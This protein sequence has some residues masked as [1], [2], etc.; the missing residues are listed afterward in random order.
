M[1]ASAGIKSP[2]RSRRNVE[3]LTIQS[4]D[5]GK[6]MDQNF[7]LK[8]TQSAT[9]KKPE[10]DSQPFGGLRTT[11]KQQNKKATK[12]ENEKDYRK[13]Q[14]TAST[15]HSFRNA[16]LTNEDLFTLGKSQGSNQEKIRPRVSENSK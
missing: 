6:G 1:P 5:L 10:K 16:G 8:V 12:E 4:L 9:N 7:N 3:D 15:L 11:L 2:P 14:S 13:V